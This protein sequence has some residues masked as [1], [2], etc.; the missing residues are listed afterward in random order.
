MKVKI[1]YF[2]LFSLFLINYSVSY[3][4]EKI[5]IVAKVNNQIVTN[6]DVKK[7]VSYL[8]LLNPKLNNLNKNQIN[9]LAKKSLINETIKKK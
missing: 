3:S 9:E 6:I 7:E 5:F 4:N 8:T 1:L 2:L